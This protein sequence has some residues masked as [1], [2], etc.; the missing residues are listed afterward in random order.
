MHR[1]R[2][3]LH[4]SMLPRREFLKSLAASSGLLQTGSSRPK[5]LGL[6]DRQDLV[7]RHNPLIRILDPLSPLSLGNGEFA[8]TAD[9]TGLQ[10]FPEEYDRTM[11]LCTMSQWGWHTAPQPEELRAQ[12]FRLTLFE[13]HGRK[14]GYAVDAEG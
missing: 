14:V 8:F 7:R 9:I 2:S 1:L 3:M 5:N 13:A 4:Q 12:K 6:I 10:T 11:P